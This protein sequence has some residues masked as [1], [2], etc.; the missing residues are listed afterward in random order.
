MTD[1]VIQIDPE[2]Q[3]GGVIRGRRPID[4]VKR[5]GHLSHV[6]AQLRIGEFT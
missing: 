5:I 2:I 4:F 3:G 1:T 6:I